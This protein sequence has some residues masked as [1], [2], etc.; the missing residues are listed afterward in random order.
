M[1]AVPDLDALPSG[2]PRLRCLA[3]YWRAAR[4]APGLLPGR[5]HLDPA[6]I[7]KLLPWL[8]LFD[9]ARPGPRFRYRLVGTALV[10]MMDQDPT[11][12]WLDEVHPAFR[13]SVAYPQ[14]VEVAE[15]AVPDYWRGRP[16]FH[17]TKDFVSMER[18]LLPLAR[19]GRTVD[20]LVSVT[21]YEARGW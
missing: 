3:D 21:A 18:L 11:G 14:F 10:R 12:R 6:E 20:M 15:D 13:G 9:V 16:S 2:D 8:C 5:Q 1:T 17:T 4:P 7:P 19:D